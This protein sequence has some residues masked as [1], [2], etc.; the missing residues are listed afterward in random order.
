MDRVTKMKNSKTR[1]DDRKNAEIQKKIAEEERKNKE[2]MAKGQ[3]P[4]TFEEM[5]QQTAD[6][7]AKK[8]AEAERQR[9]RKIFG[10]RGSPSEESIPP[11]EWLEFS[12]E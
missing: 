4:R 12:S 6:T 11:K 2:A 5:T 9:V 7:A 10:R 3:C 8:T 1:I